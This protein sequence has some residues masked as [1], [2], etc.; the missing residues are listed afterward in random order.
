[1]CSECSRFM[2]DK[3]G[4][5]NS[6]RKVESNK[7]TPALQTFF[8]EI[9]NELCNRTIYLFIA[10]IMRMCDAIVFININQVRVVFLDF[11]L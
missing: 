9:R 3:K 1:M 6:F 11:F 4:L 8:Y 7:K 2:Q 5:A 10:T